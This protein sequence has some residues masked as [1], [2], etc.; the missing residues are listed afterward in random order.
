M[1]RPAI[2]AIVP[3]HNGATYI[4]DALQSIRAQTCPVAELI[5]VDDG[6][7][8]DTAAIVRR[9]EPEAVLIRQPRGGPSISKNAGAAQASF[10]WLAFLDHDD[11]WPAQRN[12]VLLNGLHRQPN[13]GFAYGR[14]CF[15]EMAD[16]AI[17]ERLKKI[18]N[19]AIPFLLPS[20]LIR[21]D[22]WQ[23]IGGLNPSRNRSEDVDFYLRLRDAGVP[24]ACVEA[25]TLIY[26]L[27]GGNLSRAAALNNAA[28]LEVMHDAIRRRRGSI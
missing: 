11:L 19:T 20:A 14:L 17:D 23:S 24:I 6:S 9:V 5:V 4:A 26:R 22:I 21:R 10:N 18:D 25:T 7:T 13:A 3:V 2:S 16:G 15:S 1:S 27:H 8:D 12:E 28:M